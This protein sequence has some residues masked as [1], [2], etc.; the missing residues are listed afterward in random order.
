MPSNTLA[1]PTRTNRKSRASP[2][3][4]CFRCPE[5]GTQRTTRRRMSVHPLLRTRRGGRMQGL[6]LRGGGRRQ[7]RQCWGGAR[8]HAHYDSRHDRGCICCRHVQKSIRNSHLNCSNVKDS[9]RRVS[10]LPVVNARLTGFAI[11][12]RRVIDIII[13]TVPHHFAIGVT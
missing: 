1:K 9:A 7:G 8:Q 12:K 13:S 11:N 3:G 2:L 10:T 4:R 6:Q 5:I